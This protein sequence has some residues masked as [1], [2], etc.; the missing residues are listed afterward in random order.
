MNNNYLKQID[1]QVDLQELNKDLD[2]ILSNHDFKWNQFGFT[3]RPKTKMEKLHHD[4]V[5]PFH[6]EE[7][8]QEADLPFPKS[9]SDWSEFIPTFVGSYFH[10]IYKNVPIEFGRM[11]IIELLPK[12][13]LSVHTDFQDRHH[14]VIRTNPTAYIFFEESDETR[15]VDK[16]PGDGHLYWAKTSIKHTTFNGSFSEPRYHLLFS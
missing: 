1:F 9:E 2:Y 7:R 6:Y 13:C 4:S 10:W 3:Y 14:I 8:E 15:Y 5:G 12:K 11:R 16:I